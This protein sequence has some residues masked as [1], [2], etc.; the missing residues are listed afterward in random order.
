MHLLLKLI[1]I[2]KPLLKEKLALT[3]LVNQVV[4][5]HVLR[6]KKQA[7]Q[8]HAIMVRKLVVQN[9]ADTEARKVSKKLKLFP[10]QN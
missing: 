4:Q 10:Y 7:V 8:N 1:V 2:T 9:H 5:S 6:V 3:K